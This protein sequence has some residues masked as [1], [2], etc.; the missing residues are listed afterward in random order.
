VFLKPERL[1]LV[2]DPGFTLTTVINSP[3]FRPCVC[4]C[5]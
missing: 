5:V 1:L 4:V 2:L 3:T